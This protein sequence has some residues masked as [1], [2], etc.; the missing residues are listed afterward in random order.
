MIDSLSVKNPFHPI[1]SFAV[2][3]VSLIF[4]MLISKTLWVFAFIALAITVY[5]CFGMSKCTFRILT[6]MLILGCVIGG[7]ALLTS[8]NLL[9]LWQT[10]GRMLLLGICS[11]PMITVPPARLTR[12]LTQMKCPRMITL[13]MLITIRFIPIIIAEINKIR[14]AMKVRGVSM[15]IYRPDLIYRAF[16]IPLIMRV[17]GISDILSLSLE[18]RGFRLDN[19]EASVYQ[20]VTVRRRDIIFLIMNIL[21]IVGTEVVKCLVH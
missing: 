18:T 11:V 8:R 5:I 17:I 1:I 21:S 6:V 3:L 12:C 20:P 4:G 10:I 9:S 15:S 7:F 14:E 19:R 13:G 2:S 16:F